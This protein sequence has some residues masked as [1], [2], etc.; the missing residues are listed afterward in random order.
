MSRNFEALKSVALGALVALCLCLFLNDR[1]A[2]RGVPYTAKQLDDSSDTAEKDVA[3]RLRDVV[4]ELQSTVLAVQEAAVAM[5]EAAVAMRSSAVQREPSSSTSL[6]LPVAPAAQQQQ[7]VTAAASS[8]FDPNVPQSVLEFYRKNGFKAC[9]TSVPKGEC[10]LS[11]TKYVDCTKLFQQYLTTMATHKPVSP[12]P[13]NMPPEWKDLYL[14]D[15][16]VELDSWYISEVSADTGTGPALVLSQQ[17]LDNLTA[18]AKTRPDSFGPYNTH[19]RAIYG[20]LDCHPVSGLAGAVFGTRDPW[21]EALLLA[22]GEYW[23]CCCGLCNNVWWAGS[24]LW[25]AIAQLR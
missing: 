2:T 19:V 14:L 13:E 11:L 22:N 12:A 7:L 24:C 23:M 16:A 20:A 17:H 9:Q 8:S 18:I 6:A 25:S 3:A 5:Q 21:V 4:A 1:N 15:G 10:W